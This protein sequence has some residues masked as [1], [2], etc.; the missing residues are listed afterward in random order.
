MTEIHVSA[1][2]AGSLFSSAS[3][4]V[5][6]NRNRITVDNV[7]KLLFIKMFWQTDVAGD[8]IYYVYFCCSA[9]VLYGPVTFKGYIY[10]VCVVKNKDRK[11]Q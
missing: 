7:E 9:T 5:E 2:I 3:H 1:P 8:I 10:L 4:F 6:E 11:C